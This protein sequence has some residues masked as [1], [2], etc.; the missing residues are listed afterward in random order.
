MQVVGPVFS[1]L[2]YEPKNDNFYQILFVYLF[3][4]TTLLSL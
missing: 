2:T 4:A 3:I 1:D